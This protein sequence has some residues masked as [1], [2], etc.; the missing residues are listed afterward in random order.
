LTAAERLGWVHGRARRR[1][2]EK[3][4]FNRER[5]RGGREEKRREKILFEFIVCFNFQ[6]KDWELG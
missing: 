4:N 3:R 1:R 2:R 6:A 5:G